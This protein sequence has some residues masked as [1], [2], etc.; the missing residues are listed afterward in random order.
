MAPD[1]GDEIT[2]RRRVRVALAVGCVLAAVF[3]AL[4]VP[5][6]A[7]NTIA[8]TPIDSALPGERFDGGGGGGNGFGALNPGTQ[9]GVGGDT[10]FDDQ[11]FGSNDTSV[12]FEV[13]SPEPAYWRTGAYDTYTGS[14]WEQ[15]GGTTEYSS[16]LDP[17]GLTDGE[18]PFEI[19]FDQPASAIPTAWQPRSLSGADGLQVTEQGAIRAPTQ[20]DAG[21]TISGVSQQQ[22]DDPG[23]LRAA[24]NQYPTE[25]V[26]Q[27]TQLPEDTPTRV[28]T[29]TEQL[30]ANES[31]PYDTAMAIQ[32]W[33]RNE[34]KYSLEASQ[35]SEH[36]ADTFI[37]EMDAGYCEYFATSMT[38]MLRSQD[39]PARYTVGYSTGQPVDNST[40]E[41]RG[42]NAHAW[43]EVYFP[44]VGWAKFDPT[45][46]GSRLESQS[47]VLEDELGEE[48]DLE[49]PGSPG[50]TFEPGN[51][52]DTWESNNESEDGSKWYAI[53]L[54]RTAVPGLA[55][56]IQITSDGDRASDVVVTVNG[57]EVGTTGDD[58]TVVMTVPDDDE[59]R[60]NVAS[61]GG[62][63]GTNESAALATP[64]ADW[65]WSK[66]GETD[67]LFGHSLD[68]MSLQLPVQAANDSSGSGENTTKSSV[69]GNMTGGAA[70]EQVNVTRPLKL[71]NPEANTTVDVETAA[72]VSVTGE[73]LPGETV[74]LAVTVEDVTVPDA[75]VL[76]DG[77]AVAV[78]DADGRAEVTLPAEAGN[79]TL[80][81]E[82]GPVS[83]EKIVTL[84]ELSISV[85]TGRLPLPFSPATV[86]VS[87]GEYVVDD[88]PII[89]DGEQ[90]GTTGAD[91][92]AGVR[93]PFSRAATIGASGFGMSAT[94]TVDGLFVNLGFV[95]VVGGAL[96]VV[97]V[98]LVRRRRQMSVLRQ[99]LVG[100]VDRLLTATQLALLGVVRHGGTWIRSVPSRLKR[101]FGAVSD[102]LRGRVSATEL[103]ARVRDWLDRKVMARNESS[104]EPA[105]DVS[106]GIQQAW[107]AFLAHVSVPDPAAHTP[108]ELATHAIEEDELPAE[109]V[110]ALLVAFRAVE[111]GSRPPKTHLDRAERALKQIE[112][113]ATQAHSRETEHNPSHEWVSADGGMVTSTEQN[114]ETEGE[115]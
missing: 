8:G 65:S 91:G 4:L 102:V 98:Q 67:R 100:M 42:M 109:P 101:A 62:V 93:L 12:H 60:I 53:S 77:E 37:F 69:N 5:T 1:D 35:Q 23:I 36:I 114:R 71:L 3:A 99:R 70:N 82:R 84:P 63:L 64:A 28:E 78:T 83:G 2:G 27:Y 41:V 14:G 96:V 55:V 31:T 44:D 76:L 7:S 16:P 111:Y 92:T 85:S 11:T 38:T 47:S 20:L 88:A 58:G 13:Q 104:K 54:N 21:T 81:V 17:V 68:G 45:P 90:V 52:T 74:T 66:P 105:V 59:L 19:T 24:G 29:F 108:G 95:L 97:S 113:H 87:A 43:V 18:L 49:E 61:V 34:K 106:G 80:A 72:T 46:G 73:T 9:T 30:T 32:Q 110:E 86:T 22:A 103:I 39:I 57:R 33:L 79:A 75:R 6:L 112:T 50:E 115:S 94:Q 56:E 15:D 107:E 89:V 25:I 51:I 40:Y 48:V 26:E 10:G